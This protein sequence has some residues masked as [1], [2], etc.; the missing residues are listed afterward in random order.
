M[1]F[2]EL[3]RSIQNLENISDLENL[4]AQKTV[5]L[6][7][8]TAAKVYHG[9]V[10]NVLDRGD[11]I[12]EIYHTDRLTA[13]DCMIT[14]VPFKGIILNGMAAWWFNQIDFMPHHFLS[15]L[16][17]RSIACKKLTPFKIEIVV[18]G[19]LAG[20]M[21]RDYLIG[22][23]EISGQKIPEGLNPFQKLPCTIITP[24]T[25]APVFEHDEDTTA[26]QL[27]H[28]G[29]CNAQEWEIITSHALKLFDFGSRV[30]RAK[31]WILVDTKYEFGKDAE[32]NIYLIDEV[33]TPDSSRFWKSESY[34]NR[35]AHKLEPEMLDKENVRQYLI[36]QGFKGR[37]SV[38]EIPF[39]EIKRL[40][41]T[42]LEVFLSL[43]TPES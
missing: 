16:T 4:L 32:G 7:I 38:P 34:A 9:K 17:D 6:K 13:F 41:T 36:R 23:R 21:L 5:G 27:I 2:D 19:Y 33:H 18:R 11:G 28:T 31:G 30:L 15:R 1:N 35:L 26:V 3:G 40:L 43:S 37:G 8:P 14:N 39:V 25:K 10:R 24:T 12:L 20:S 42:Y 29:I 22:R